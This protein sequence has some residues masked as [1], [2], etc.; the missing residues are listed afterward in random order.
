M[1]KVGRP[2]DY[3]IELAEE[4]CD[5]IA[6]SSKGLKPLCNANNHWP[7]RK[8]IYQWIK[9]HPEFRS[10]YAQ[11]KEHQ[12]EVIVNEIL[13]IADDTSKDTIIKTNKDGVEY[14]TCNSE[15][16]NRSRLRVDTRKWLAAKLCPRLYGDMAGKNEVSQDAKS[17]VERI[18]D[19]L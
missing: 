7:D 14:E 8:N 15:Y 19:K 12:I 9:K 5:A 11:A 10:M 6:C 2:T 4:I 13:E 17:L 1:A 16:I 18:I 3:T